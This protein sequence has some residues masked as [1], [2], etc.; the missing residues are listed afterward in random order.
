[1]K[2]IRK[3]N[4]NDVRFLMFSPFVSEN[5]SFNGCYVLKMDECPKW[6]MKN[7]EKSS[8]KET[9]YPE[10]KYLKGWR[11]TPHDSEMIEKVLSA[12]K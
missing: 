2:G 3:V 9:P 5:S 10:Y 8:K 11:V 12:L 7:W 6:D 4:R 1:M